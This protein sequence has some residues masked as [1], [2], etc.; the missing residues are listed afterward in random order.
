MGLGAGGGVVGGEGEGMKLALSNVKLDPRP[1][2][3][4]LDAL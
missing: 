1:A 2:T 4:C 3:R